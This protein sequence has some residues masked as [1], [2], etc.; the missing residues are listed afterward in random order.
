MSSAAR[1][2]KKQAAAGGNAKKPITLTQKAANEAAS[3]STDI[4]DATTTTTG[5]HHDDHHMNGKDSHHLNGTTNGH[6]SSNNGSNGSVEVTSR[7]VKVASAQ[8]PAGKRKWALDEYGDR[9]IQGDMPVPVGFVRGWKSDGDEK[10]SKISAADQKELVQKSAMALATAPGKQLFMTAFMLYMSGNS[11]QIFSIMMLGMA[12]WQPLQKMFNVSQEFA[13]YADS[14]ADLTM[15][16]LT[17]VALNICGVLLA[18][19]KCH[20]LGLLPTLAD[21]APVPAVKQ[22]VEFSAGAIARRF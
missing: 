9:D 6:V 4:D 13:R 18:C 17:F 5:D 20:S 12:F 21:L 1:L 19:Y 14:P 15:A 10:S 2:R 16:K 22:A 7:T 3:T 8:Q 11:L